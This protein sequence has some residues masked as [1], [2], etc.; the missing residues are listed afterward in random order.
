[1]SGCTTPVVVPV[2]NPLQV[3]KQLQESCKNLPKLENAVGKPLD[4]VVLQNRLDSEV[5]IADCYAK[6]QGVLT[7][8]GLKLPSKD[9]LS[10]WELFKSKLNQT[11]L[12]KE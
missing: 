11:K 8:A 1:M 9:K 4:E 12:I 3:S 5:V 6:H 2:V 10:R 7:A